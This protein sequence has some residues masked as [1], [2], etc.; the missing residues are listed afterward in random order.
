MERRRNYGPTGSSGGRFKSAPAAV[1]SVAPWRSVTNASAGSPAFLASSGSRRAGSSIG[2]SVR[3]QAAAGAEG[4][5][6]GVP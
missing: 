2:S 4:T 5:L 6:A 1:A 3:L